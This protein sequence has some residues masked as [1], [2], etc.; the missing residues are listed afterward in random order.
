[1]LFEQRLASSNGTA[2]ARRDTSN[3]SLLQVHDLGVGRVVTGG[4]ERKPVAIRR[5]R[6]RKVGRVAAADLSYAASVG[7]EQVDLWQSHAI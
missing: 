4:G 6:G 3:V 5:S 2:G 1:M 7:I